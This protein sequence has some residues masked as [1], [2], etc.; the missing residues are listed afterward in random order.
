M[1]SLTE[2][3]RK[4]GYARQRQVHLWKRDNPDREEF[5]LGQACERA[6][7]SILQVEA[8]VAYKTRHLWFNLQ[9]SDNEQVIMIDLPDTKEGKG[10]K[11]RR[12][13][14]ADYCAEQGIPLIIIPRHIGVQEMQAILQMELWKIRRKN[15]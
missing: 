6:K 4:A 2:K 13:L 5:R 7:V 11:E 14:K 8:E 3:R 12:A 1:T 9:I 15:E 10:T